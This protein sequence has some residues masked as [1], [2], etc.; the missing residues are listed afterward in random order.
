MTGTEPMTA[1]MR[2]VRFH[3]YGEPG[4]V[5]RLSAVAP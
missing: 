3:E 4:Q 1:T 5:L 2:T